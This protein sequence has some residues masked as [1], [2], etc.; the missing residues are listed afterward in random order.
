LREHTADVPFAT[1]A[2]PGKRYY[3]QFGVESSPRAVLDPRSWS[4]VVRGVLL[5]A[6]GRFRAPA[7]KQEGG[8][9]GLPADFLIGTEGRV[10]AKK[11]GKHAY[12]QW[13]V[14]ELL[15][16]AQARHQAS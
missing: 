14:D 9:L 10:L 5:T 12:D 6:S 4:A 13:S 2:D 11:Y 15:A 16:H 1:V 7:I 3:R 8:H